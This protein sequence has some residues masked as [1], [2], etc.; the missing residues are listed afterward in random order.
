[1]T[2]LY[3]AFYSRSLL[4]ATDTEYEGGPPAK[5]RRRLALGID[6]SLAKR[7]NEEKELFAELFPAGIPKTVDTEDGV[8]KR[9]LEHES[10]D[11]DDDDGDE[12]LLVRFVPLRV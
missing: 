4:F 3:S 12:D 8:G 7:R 10:H 11:C 6:T 2:F 5:K 9:R 1:M